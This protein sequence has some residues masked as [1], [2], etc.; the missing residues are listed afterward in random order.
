VDYRA[1]QPF[2]SDELLAWMNGRFLQLPPA[3]RD[4][5][6]D[7]LVGLA[8][9]GAEKAARGEP[10][11]YFDRFWG[12]LAAPYFLL[13]SK[14]WASPADVPGEP[15]VGLRLYHDTWNLQERRANPDAVE[16]S[17]QYEYRRQ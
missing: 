8:A 11:G 9:R 16:R 10:I 4:L 3:D 12:P 7:Y 6:A 1:W 15:L 17:I 14:W 5:A 13:H 2:V